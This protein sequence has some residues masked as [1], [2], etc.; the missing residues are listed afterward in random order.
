MLDEIQEEC[1]DQAGDGR[2]AGGLWLRLSEIARA[3]DAVR[4]AIVTSSH[5]AYKRGATMGDKVLN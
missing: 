1:V 4:E 3:A 5:E 2:G